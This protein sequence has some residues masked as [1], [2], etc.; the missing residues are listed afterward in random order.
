MTHA[1][2]NN[3]NRS[4]LV[5]LS[6][7]AQVNSDNQV[8]HLQIEE[9]P[10]IGDLQLDADPDNHALLIAVGDMMGV[11][12]PLT[13]SR[14]S[15]L[16]TLAIIWL[17]QV[18]LQNRRGE[19]IKRNKPD[20]PRWLVLPRPGL[21]LQPAE[22][23]AQAFG[24]DLTLAQHADTIHLQLTDAAV[25]YLLDSQNTREEQAAQLRREQAAQQL[26]DQG[27][28]LLPLTAFNR[29]DLLIRRSCADQLWQWLDNN[30]GALES[31]NAEA[32]RS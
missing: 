20:Q 29:Y 24:Q 32:A 21:T 18:P 31:D 11:Q 28:T 1:Q 2:N 30:H 22:A 13:A 26:Q 10:F 6:L 19:L 12:Q 4:P 17:D 3:E 16:S 25:R 23:L 7:G 5:H 27:A 8:N 9:Q 15:C 14:I